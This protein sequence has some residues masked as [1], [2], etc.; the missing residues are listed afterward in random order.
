MTERAP[1]GSAPAATAAPSRARVPFWDNVRFAC[2]VL[3]VV[4]H[5]VQRLAQ[6]SDAAMTLYMLIYAFHM[7]AFAIISGYFS[8]GDA[9]SRQRM[10]RLITDI[11]VPYVLFEAIWSVTKLLVE[12]HEDFNFTKPSWTLWFLLAL[13]IFRLILPYLALLRWPLLWSLVVSV[14][15]G[16]LPNLDSTFALNRTLAL[17]PFFV[18]GWWLSEHD[19]MARLRLLAARPWWV[20]VAALAVIAGTACALWFGLDGWQEMSLRRWFF[21]DSSY[22]SLGNPQWW[23]GGI[24]LLLIVI[25]VVLSCAFAALVPLRHTWWTHLGQYTMYVYLLHTFVLYPF[26]ESGALRG[27]EPVWLWLPLVVVLS[28]ALAIVL[29]SKPV[30][31]VFRGLVEPR[32][33][34]L[35]AERA[36]VSRRQPAPAAGSGQPA[37]STPPAAR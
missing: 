28:V 24:R 11:V 31:I 37:R 9:P 23:A 20:P 12:G 29:A 18:L 2:I 14:G 22:A 26:R 35:F 34:W 13:A 10:A 27:L 19:V 25:A 15:A 3:V 36:L 4:G 8:K 17:L 33:A 6:D 5:A 7:P 21:Y 1:A 30:R 32:A 16:Y